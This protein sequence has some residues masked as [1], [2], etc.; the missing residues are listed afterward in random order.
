MRLKENPRPA[1][2][3]KLGYISNQAAVFAAVPVFPQSKR[4]KLTYGVLRRNSQVE[5][6]FVTRTNP[7]NGG[8]TG[9][10]VA[11][12]YKPNTW[13]FLKFRMTNELLFS[14]AYG[15]TLA[16]G[17][18]NV[19]SDPNLSSQYILNWLFCQLQALYF[20]FASRQIWRSI[21]LSQTLASLST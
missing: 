7:S 21:V 10:T 9:C 1:C 20:R 11:V 3:L 13:S 19:W 16:G 18:F 5:Y 14:C 15:V 17:T 2:N 8:E 4:A 12:S 6:G